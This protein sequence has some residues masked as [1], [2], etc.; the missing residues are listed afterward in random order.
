L[1]MSI[2]MHNYQALLHKST[3][4]LHRWHGNVSVR[5]CSCCT[6]NISCVTL[7]CCIYKGFICCLEMFH[8]ICYVAQ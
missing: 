4:M 3:H 5:A 2:I 1:V 6:Y 7:P 8:I